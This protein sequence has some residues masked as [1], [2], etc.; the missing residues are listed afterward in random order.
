M[1]PSKDLGMQPMEVDDFGKPL[2][3]LDRTEMEFFAAEIG[4]TDENLLLERLALLGEEI[5]NLD[6]ESFNAPERF[7]KLKMKQLSAY[8]YVLGWGGLSGSI[9]LDV[10]C[11]LGIDV[12]KAV[13]D[14]FPPEQI[15]A[16]DVRKDLW[17]LGNRL[18]KP[19]SDKCA[20]HFIHTDVML[21]EPREPCY[22]VPVIRHP[23]LS[24]QR[25]LT[26]LYNQVTCIHAGDIFHRLSEPEQRGLAKRLGGLLCGMGGCVIFGQQPGM[27][28][29]GPKVDGGVEIYCHSPESW[30]DIWDGWV[31]NEG[32]VKCSTHLVEIETVAKEKGNVKVE[33]E[34]EFTLVW[35]VMRN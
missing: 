21:L 11:G 22:E 18:F 24:T 17:E 2:P 34:R 3:S 27:T 29:P 30:K 8:E 28:R 20:I 32:S 9:L 35:W 1:M 33:T 26:L 15:I 25:D 4:E 19:R 14:G 6:P 5:C 7:A 16:T 10:G 23:V 12:R 31:F 13:A